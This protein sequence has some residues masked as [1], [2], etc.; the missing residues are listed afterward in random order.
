MDEIVL[1]HFATLRL[2]KETC[3]DWYGT[4]ESLPLQLTCLD[5]CLPVAAAAGAVSVLEAYVAGREQVD[6][7]CC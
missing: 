2:G 1:A 7:T 3:P 6:T 5:N 4:V